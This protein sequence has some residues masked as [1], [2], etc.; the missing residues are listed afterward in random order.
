[1]S[2]EIV[3]PASTR[4]DLRI[5]EVEV[6]R[7]LLADPLPGVPYS[8]NPYV[9]CAHAC[10]FSYIP[11]LRHED[12]RVWGTYV[13]VKRNAPTLLALEVRHRP[14]ERTPVQRGLFEGKGGARTRAKLLTATVHRPRIGR[15][16]RGSPR[17]SAQ[18]G[19]TE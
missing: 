10:S 7:A 14:R 18:G 6:E 5:V 3:R 8:F 4:T 19:N 12:R 17:P 2:I 9:G 13:Q 1:M 15:R 16:S 11:R